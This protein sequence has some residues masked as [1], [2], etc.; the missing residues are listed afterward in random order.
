M[1]FSLFG[2]MVLS[3]MLGVSAALSACIFN[4]LYYNHAI[5]NLEQRACIRIF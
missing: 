2:C 3:I 1:I 4:Q 5:D